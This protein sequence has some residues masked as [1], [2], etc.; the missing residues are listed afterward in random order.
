LAG[1][2]FEFGFAYG[3]RIMKKQLPHVNEILHQGMFSQWRLGKR[4][5]W[6]KASVKEFLQ[7]FLIRIEPTLHPNTYKDYS[8]VVRDH[9]IP[10]IGSIK[11]KNLNADHIQT[12]YSFKLENDTSPTRV[13]FIHKVLRRALNLAVRWNYLERNP[14]NFVT[15]PARNRRE[16]KTFSV[17]EVKI[18]L[19]AIEGSRLE[20]LFHLAVT[21]GLRLS[22]ILGLKWPD[23]GWETG[24]LRITRQLQRVPEKGLI[25]SEPKSASSRRN[26]VIGPTTLHKLKEHKGNHDIEREQYVERWQD[27]DLIFTTLKGSPIGPR[28]LYR[29]FKSIIRSAGLP[30][31]RFHD[32]RHTCA[33]MMLQSGVN[34]KVIQTVLGHSSVVITLDTYS[35]LLPGMQ[36]E[37][38]EMVDSLITKN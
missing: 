22:E 27:L 17:K 3:E 32:L 28:N 24:S 6:N 29:E 4:K 11:L 13:R 2:P 18:F 37:A 30:D 12:L 23:L 9:L 36:A 26:I 1:C 19:E 8:Q 35:H 38:A 25:F 21:S 16:M 5:N 33:T 15:V 14:A 20:A 7:L 34:V 10:H 31:I